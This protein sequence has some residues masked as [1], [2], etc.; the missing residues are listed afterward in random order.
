MNRDV[1]EQIDEELQWIG[2]S[3]GLFNLRDKDK[4]CY[5]IFITLLKNA[6]DQ[7]ILS[8]DELAYITGLSRGTV[9]HHLNKM[10]SSNIIRLVDNGYVLRGKN[11][12]ELI[13]LLKNDSIKLF[14]DLK[15][16]AEKVDKKM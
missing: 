9:V 11:L 14:D 7:K 10:L 5:R 6:K 13:E 15:K 12:I 3:L 1:P 8:S 16:V 4:S 2:S